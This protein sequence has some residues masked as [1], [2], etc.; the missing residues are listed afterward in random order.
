MFSSLRNMYLSATP[1]LYTYPP[2]SISLV[3]SSGQEIGLC[4]IALYFPGW[5]VICRG[6]KQPALRLKAM[7]GITVMGLGQGP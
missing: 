4:V 2:F 5:E 6:L 1:T 3:M 7:T